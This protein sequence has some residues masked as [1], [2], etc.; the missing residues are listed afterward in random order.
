[1]AFYRLLYVIFVKYIKKIKLN[2]SDYF[3]KLLVFFYRLKLK[4][5][6]KLNGS[7]KSFNLNKLVFFYSCTLT[8]NFNLTHVLSQ[9][10]EFGKN[11]SH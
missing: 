5:F 8:L 9:C 10:I 3:V 2:L 11:A 6:E 4:Q 1:M 7:Q